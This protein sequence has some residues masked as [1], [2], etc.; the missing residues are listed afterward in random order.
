MPLESNGIFRC[1]EF[2]RFQHQSRHHDT[3]VCLCRSLHNYCILSQG[4]NVRGSEPR[5]LPW[6]SNGNNR[7]G[8]NGRWAISR[9][10]CTNFFPFG[11]WKRRNHCPPVILRF[12]KTPIEKR[13]NN[14]SRLYKSIHEGHLCSVIIITFPFDLKFSRFQH[15]D[16][17]TIYRKPVIL[18]SLGKTMESI[19]KN[20]K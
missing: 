9:G 4:L 18:T 12:W 17:F 5:W 10:R 13:A 20:N 16:M 3:M 11:T 1:Q 6:S 19:C 15:Q 2:S 7:L 8:S 14:K